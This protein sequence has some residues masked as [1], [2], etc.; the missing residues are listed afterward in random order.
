MSTA[1]AR[2][3]VAPISRIL[4]AQIRSVLLGYWRMP[5]FT[6]FSMVLPIMFF[7]FFGLP[8]IHNT[9]APGVTVGAYVLA[10]M[11]AYGMSNVLV[12]NIGIGQA[13]QRAR[14]LDLLQR[15]TPLPASVAIA[16]N[17]VGGL[18]L[19][20]VSLLGVLAVAAIGG[21]HLEAQRWVML[22]LAVIFGSMPMLGFGLILGYG[23]GPNAAPALASLIYLPMAFASGLF[24]P[25]SQMPAFVQDIG[26]YLPLY[27]LGQ[28]AWNTVGTSD[29]PVWQA[30]AWVVGWSIVLFGIA[31]RAYRV[32]QLRKFA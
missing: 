9:M 29:E 31:I 27:H 7:S 22:P 3:D 21:V 26:R 23:S 19:A 11:A 15:A 24:I 14:K 12:Y 10:S 1:M 13:N 30:A 16:A 32:D 18:A 6:I 25:L 8:N 2:P 17:L 5:Y 20:L 28:L 4:W